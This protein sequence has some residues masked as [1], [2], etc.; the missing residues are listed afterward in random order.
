M[1]KYNIIYCDPPWKFN[2]K[3][4]GGSMSSGS[5]NKYSVLNSLQLK[6]IN[7]PNIAADDC[8]LFM[9]WVASM[10]EEAIQLVKDWDFTLK[11]MTA[12][13]WIKKTK[14]WKDYFGMGFSTRQQQEHCLLATRGKPQRVSASIRQNIR[15]VNLKH[16]QK[17]IEVKDKIIELCGNLPRIELFARK[18]DPNWHTWGDELSE[19][20]IVGELNTLNIYQ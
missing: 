1:N 17:P 20:N 11:T 2:N 3:N 15:A 10:P 16:S 14:N 9:W 4:T 18:R 12:F 7:I 8:F 5:A 19:G 6:E 13:S